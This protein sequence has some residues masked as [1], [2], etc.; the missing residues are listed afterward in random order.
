MTLCANIQTEHINCLTIYRWR[1]V[2]EI[3]SMT[4]YK[5]EVTEIKSMT[6]YKWEV[7]E[8]KSMAIYRWREVT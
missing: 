6:I 2:T 1:G 4:V 3:K 5:W 8:I 7:T